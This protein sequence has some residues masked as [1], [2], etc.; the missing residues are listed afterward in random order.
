MTEIIQSLTDYI[1]SLEQRLDSIEKYMEKSQ[2]DTAFLV[3][4]ISDLEQRVATADRNESQ[5]LAR[6]AALQQQVDEL[7]HSIANSAIVESQVSDIQEDNTIAQ[8]EVVK[9]EVNNLSSNVNPESPLPDSSEDISGHALEDA[10]PV[11]I[12]DAT[13]TQSGDIETVNKETSAN[14]NVNKASSTLYGTPVDDLKLAISIGDRFLYQRE[15]FTQN[16]ELMQK[17]LNAL[18]AL[19]SFDEAIAYLDAHFDWDKESNTYNL[20]LTALHRRFS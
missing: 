12:A 3:T 10:I 8:T 2:Q 17:T 7:Q 4:R 14:T 16:G 6:I 13:P 18:N 5:F 9:T 11:S 19:N 20:F 1:N 15:L